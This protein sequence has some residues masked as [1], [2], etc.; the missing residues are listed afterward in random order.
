[1]GAKTTR[2]KCATERAGSIRGGEYRLAKERAVTR[3]ELGSVPTTVSEILPVTVS[4][5]P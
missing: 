1:M 2:S 4:D 3:R 5:S